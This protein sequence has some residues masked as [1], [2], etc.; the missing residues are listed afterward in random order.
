MI[1]AL[2]FDA[3]H[4]KYISIRFFPLRW[5]FLWWHSV[6]FSVFVFMQFGTY[7]AWM[8]YS[9]IIIWIRNSIVSASSSSFW[10]FRKIF[11]AKSDLLQIVRIYCWLLFF[12]CSVFY[13]WFVHDITNKNWKHTL[14]LSRLF[15]NVRR[16]SSSSSPIPLMRKRGNGV[17]RPSFWIKSIH[18]THAHRLH[19]T[20]NDHLSC[21]H[22]F[23][24][25]RS[26]VVAKWIP[27][28]LFL[29]HTPKIHRIMYR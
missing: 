15:A 13:L 7:L 25:Y 27:A 6:S 28:K 11:L 16:F 5:I 9:S 3:K 12:R 10:Y 2:D 17:N 1:K 4:T 20:I 22:H 19:T 23:P 29:T 14:F 26:I 8:E 21:G 24:Y 18:C